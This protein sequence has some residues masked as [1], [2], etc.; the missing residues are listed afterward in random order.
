MF[1]LLKKYIEIHISVWI[2]LNCDCI[3]MNKSVIKCGF[4]KLICLNKVFNSNQIMQN[5]VLPKKNLSM[6]M[7]ETRMKKLIVLNE[8]NWFKFAV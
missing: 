6:G 1:K 8:M 5:T 7:I 2:K 4:S 3:K